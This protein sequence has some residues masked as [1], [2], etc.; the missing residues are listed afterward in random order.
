MAISGKGTWK[1]TLFASN[2]EL[3]TVH[4]DCLTYF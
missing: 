1:S 4:C 3:L 2:I